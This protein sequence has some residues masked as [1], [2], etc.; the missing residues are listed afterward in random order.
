[1]SNTMKHFDRE[2]KIMQDKLE[3]GDKLIIQDYI[4]SIRKI[5]K[6]CVGQGHS[7][8]SIHPYANAMGRTIKNAML[9]QPLSP[10][11]GDDSEWTEVGETI[12]DTSQNK[13]CSAVFKTNKTGKSHYLDAV[14]FQGEDKHD[15]FTGQVED[16]RSRQYVKFPFTPKTFYINVVREKYAES[17]HGNK[18]KATSCGDGD[19]VYFIK[20]RKQLEEV[21]EYYD[22]YPG[23]GERRPEPSSEN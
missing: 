13:R 3:E 22:E 14:V 18:A 12:P 9:M 11:T 1:M 15:S 16:I 10:I 8:M 19:Y 23:D 4:P 7:G 2:L 5:L 6:I 17:K 20:D 21:F